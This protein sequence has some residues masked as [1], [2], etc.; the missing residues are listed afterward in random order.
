MSLEETP[1]FKK[2]TESCQAR[3][4][5]VAKKPIEKV[6]IPVP[7]NSSEI[8]GIN[9]NTPEERVEKGPS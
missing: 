7:K 5:T 6:E 4:E 8:T 2:I 3:E 1:A 9:R